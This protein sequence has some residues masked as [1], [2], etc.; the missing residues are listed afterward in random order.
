MNLDYLTRVSFQKIIFLQ[1]NQKKICYKISRQTA[2]RLKVDDLMIWFLH[3]KSILTGLNLMEYLVK[4]VKMSS[5]NW[6]S[7]S[8]KHFYKTMVVYNCIQIF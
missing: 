1:S 4:N 2:F 6:S 7:S 5:A 3:W 8:F